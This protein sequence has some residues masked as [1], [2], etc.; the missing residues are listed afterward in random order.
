MC[1][2]DH[3]RILYFTKTLLKYKLEQKIVFYNLRIHHN[4][5]SQLV[6]INQN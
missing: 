4:Y 1:V 6:P 2:D 3:Q 5:R